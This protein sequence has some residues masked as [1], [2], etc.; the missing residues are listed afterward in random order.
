LLLVLVTL[1]Q[2]LTES[3]TLT[4]IIQLYNRNQQEAWLSQRDCASAAHHTGVKNKKP[5]CR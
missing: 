1:A 4:V 2:C 3:E 5:S